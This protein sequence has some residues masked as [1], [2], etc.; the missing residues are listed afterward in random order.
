MFNVN[1][2]EVVKGYA[3]DF[4]LGTYAYSMLI[5]CLGYL[6]SNFTFNGTVGVLGVIIRYFYPEYLD[7]ES[8]LPSSEAEGGNLKKK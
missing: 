7:D 5:L 3:K 1:S 6:L 2:A 8:E 4:S